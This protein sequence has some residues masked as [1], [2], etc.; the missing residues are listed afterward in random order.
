MKMLNSELEKLI[1]IKTADESKN[2]ESLKEELT[3]NKI[4]YKT[5]SE[6]RED[7]LIFSFGYNDYGNEQGYSIA[8]N[9]KGI[10]ALSTYGFQC[11][12]PMLLD[13]YHDW[14]GILNWVVNDRVDKDA[15]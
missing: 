15:W 14:Q 10:F 6:R 3:Y 13:D 1:A 2:L 9:G 4:P 8:Y 12:P 7:V 11:S 5:K